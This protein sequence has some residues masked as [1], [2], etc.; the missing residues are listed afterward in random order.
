MWT[1][2]ILG[3]EQDIKSWTLNMQVKPRILHLMEHY[4]GT[5]R[6]QKTITHILDNGE[7]TPTRRPSAT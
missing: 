4:K 3:V 2:P 1:G 6:E 5:Q 7:T